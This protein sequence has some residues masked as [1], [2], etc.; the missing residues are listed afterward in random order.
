MV[1]NHHAMEHAQ[2]HRID[3]VGRLKFNFHTGGGGGG[4]SHKS[5]SQKA[6]DVVSGVVEH[7]LE[8]RNRNDR[9]MKHLKDVARRHGNS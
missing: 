1:W 3:G 6:L 9:A 4:G 7:A 5:L 8:V 2:Q